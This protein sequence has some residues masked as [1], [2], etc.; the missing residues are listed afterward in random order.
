MCAA[1]IMHVALCSV[2]FEVVILFVSL[3]GKSPLLLITFSTSLSQ[4]RIG[5]WFPV[6]ILCADSAAS[7]C[8]PPTADFVRHP[9]TFCAL[10]NPVL[11][12]FDTRGA[13][14]KALLGKASGYF[15]LRRR[16]L[17]TGPSLAPRRF[18]VGV[19]CAFPRPGPAPPLFAGHFS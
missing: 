2:N 9:H 15:S 13:S 12:E 14:Q 7:L 18:R 11:T 8:M 3:L 5:E 16:T 10:V 19:A 17:R 6:A 4:S 1:P